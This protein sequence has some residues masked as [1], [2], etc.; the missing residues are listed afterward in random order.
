MIDPKDLFV[1]RVFPAYVSDF[2]QPSSPQTV[3]L[4]VNTKVPSADAD[5]RILRS[6]LFYIS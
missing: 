4:A 1:L 3:S 6:L 2:Y 5:K